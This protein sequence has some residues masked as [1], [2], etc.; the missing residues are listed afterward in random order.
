[1][2][3]CVIRYDNKLWMMLTLLHFIISHRM[4]TVNDLC[5]RVLMA[6]IRH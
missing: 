2:T 6:A 3:V 5:C 1:M 4:C